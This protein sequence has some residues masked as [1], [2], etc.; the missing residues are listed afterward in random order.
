MLQV[1]V[2]DVG[3]IREQIRPHVF[4]NIRLCQLSEVLRQFLFR[5]A[6]REVRIRLREPHLREI[7]HHLG[8][9]ER[10]REEDRVRV[11]LP[12]LRERPLPEPERFRVRIVDAEDLDAVRRPELDHALELL[13][14]PGPVFG[15]EV[16]GIDVLIFLR[17]VLGV[18]DRAVGAMAEP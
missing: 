7:A 3:R 9:R 18:F 8:P 10:L 17:R 12:D 2:E 16:E 11:S 5:V 15:F 4:A 13:P 14:Q 6:P 1:L